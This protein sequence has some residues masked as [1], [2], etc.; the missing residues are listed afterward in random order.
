MKWLCKMK[1]RWSRVGSVCGER[2]L[3]RCTRCDTTKVT[4]E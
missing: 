1:H 4:K 3:Y 2:V